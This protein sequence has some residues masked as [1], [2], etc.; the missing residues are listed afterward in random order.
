M[1]SYLFSKIKFI[2]LLKKVISK[3]HGNYMV[4]CPEVAL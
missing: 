1:K 4:S 3:K 2:F